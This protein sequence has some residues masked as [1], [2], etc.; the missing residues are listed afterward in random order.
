MEKE[1]EHSPS[2]PNCSKAFELPA[3]DEQARRSN[4]NF[5]ASGKFLEQIKTINLV[6]S[7]VSF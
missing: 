5:V 1:L 7:L 4:N 6:F 2:P 3:K